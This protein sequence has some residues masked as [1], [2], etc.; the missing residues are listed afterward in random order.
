M[1]FMFKSLLYLK[2]KIFER[3]TENSLNYSGC[4]FNLPSDSIGLILLSFVRICL[5]NGVSSFSVYFLL[6]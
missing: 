4:N 3:L 5:L 2:K 6:S 1:T